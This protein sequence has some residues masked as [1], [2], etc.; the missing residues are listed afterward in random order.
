MQITRIFE[1]DAGHRI[2]N[3]NSECRNIHGHRYKLELTLKGDILNTKGQSH[4]G[5]IL[6]FADIKKIT[7]K[8]IN[9]VDHSFLVY[10]QDNKML[11]F[12]KTTDSKYTILTDIP[13]VENIAQFL[14]K[15]LIPKFKQTYNTTLIIKKITLWETPNC[16]VTLEL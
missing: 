3:H 16:F 1:F 14:L 2:P 12:L 11:E 7:N 10:N 5:M 8:I 6:D 4:E 15:K 13:T 9:K